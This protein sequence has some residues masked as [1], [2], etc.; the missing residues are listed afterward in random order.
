MIIEILMKCMEIDVK[1]GQNI[2]GSYLMLG[3]S[4]MDRCVLF[5]DQR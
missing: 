3:L 5:D 1:D 4:Y 2:D